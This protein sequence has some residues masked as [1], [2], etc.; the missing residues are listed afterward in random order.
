M[1]IAVIGAGGAGGTGNATPTQGSF[2]KQGGTSS[3]NIGDN[4]YKSIGG[5][6]GTY[7]GNGYI[8]GVGGEFKINEVTRSRGG[9]GGTG[10]NINVNATTTAFVAGGTGGG[11]GGG[12]L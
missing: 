5:Y 7:S 4:V 6:G 8:G 2:G 12:F 3:I 1:N 11:E 9:A 10:I